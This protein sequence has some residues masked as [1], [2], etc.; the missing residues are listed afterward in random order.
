M[1][2]ASPTGCSQSS[3]GSSRSS[4]GGDVVRLER[5]IVPGEWDRVRAGTVHDVVSDSG[6]ALSVH[7]YSPPLT[8]MSF[9]KGAGDELGE[10]RAVDE[11]E[12]IIGAGRALHPSWH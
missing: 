3:M 5:P 7:V 1:I 11:G 8:S 10:H 4:G 2:T 12:P 9:F 6:E